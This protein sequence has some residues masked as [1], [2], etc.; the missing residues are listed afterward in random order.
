MKFLPQVHMISF[1]LPLKLQLKILIFDPQ[2]EVSKI[3]EE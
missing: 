1:H 2:L 3:D